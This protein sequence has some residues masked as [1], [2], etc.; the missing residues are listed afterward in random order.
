ML[1]LYNEDFIQTGG[2]DYSLKQDIH[3]KGR[4][5]HSGSGNLKL[6]SGIIE[7]DLIMGGSGDISSRGTVIIGGNLLMNGNGDLDGNFIIIGKLVNSGSG[8]VSGRI[9]ATGYNLT[10]SG[11]VY[12]KNTPL[13]PSSLQK[14]NVLLDNLSNLDYGGNEKIIQNLETSLNQPY[15]SLLK[16][17]ITLKEHHDDIVNEGGFKTGDITIE[18]SNQGNF[19]SNRNGELIAFDLMSTLNN[20][21]KQCNTDEIFDIKVT[22]EILKMKIKNG[23]LVKNIEKIIDVIEFEYELTQS[24]KLN[25]EMKMKIYGLCTFIEK[26]YFDDMLSR[27]DKDDDGGS[28]NINVKVSGIDN[29]VAVGGSSISSQRDIKK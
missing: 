14:Y 13:V 29:T 16:T 28:E 2:E 6:K 21:I 9:S 27:D 1:E 7:G 3:I 4:L 19:P 5:I 24:S 10:G 12:A 20:L 15:D 18:E 8:D 11:D 26:L 17:G 22:L 23:E 25:D